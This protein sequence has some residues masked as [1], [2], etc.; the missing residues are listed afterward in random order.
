MT[1]EITDPIKV[2]EKANIILSKINLPD[3][4]SFFQ[5][6]RFII[7]KEGT[8]QGKLWQIVREIDARMETFDSYQRQLENAEDNLELFDIQIERLNIQIRENVSLNNEIAQLNIR[9]AEININKL[10]R[11]KSGLVQ[12]CQKVKHK[13]KCVIEEIAYLSM[14]FEKI[15]QQQEIKHWDDIDVQKEI[16]EDKLLEEYNLRAIFNRPLDQEFVKTV[17]CLPEDS[18]VKQ[19][20]IRTIDTIQRQLEEKIKNKEPNDRKNIQS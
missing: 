6:E 7:G 14:G 15:S 12:S 11:D 20:M 18:N 8:I 16:W 13:L 10:Q 17:L 2:I 1:T 19:H 4:H 9:E 3:R 5:I